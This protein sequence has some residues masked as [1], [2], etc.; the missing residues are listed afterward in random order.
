MRRAESF[1]HTFVTKWVM[2]N[3]QY[4]QMKSVSKVS[5]QNSTIL[6]I[7]CEHANNEFAN[8]FFSPNWILK[9]MC[10]KGQP[11]LNFAFPWQLFTCQNPSDNY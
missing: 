10:P 7:S 4:V 6:E 1:L 11:Y 9:C 5:C 2:L 3:M 8:F